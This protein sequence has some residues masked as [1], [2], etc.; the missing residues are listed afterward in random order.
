MRKV[1]IGTSEHTRVEAVDEPSHGNAC[2]KY[3]IVEVYNQNPTAQEQKPLMCHPISFQKGPIKEHG[4]NGIHNEDL[5]AIVMDRLEGFQAGEY[6]CGE[7]GMAYAYL[8]ATLKLLRKRT[9]RR[10]AK[11]IEG[12]S[13]KDPDV[14]TL[15]EVMN[16]GLVVIDEKPDKP[17]NLEECARRIDPCNGSCYYDPASCN[18]KKVKSCE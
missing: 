1:E 10:K 9:D 13:A 12:T 5:I 7:N 2:H 17:Q 16:A 6:A 14:P 18:S 8:E 3:M 11:G 4:V 15:I